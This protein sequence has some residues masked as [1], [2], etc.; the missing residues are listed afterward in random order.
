MLMALGL[1]IIFKAFTA[2]VAFIL[3]LGL[4]NTIVDIS[5]GAFMPSD[6]NDKRLTPVSVQYQTSSA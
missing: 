5:L 3:L 2:A 6:G 1:I 4:V